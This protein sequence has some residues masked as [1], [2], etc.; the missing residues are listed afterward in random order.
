MD[1]LLFT[2]IAGAAVV[3]FVVG[4][5][6]GILPTLLLGLLIWVGLVVL[7]RHLR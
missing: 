6:S 4:V 5:M 1:D 7:H 2:L 3:A